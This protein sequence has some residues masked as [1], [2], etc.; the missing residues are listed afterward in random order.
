MLGEE[1][2][3]A[4]KKKEWLKKCGRKVNKNQHKLCL[5]SRNFIV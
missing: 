5:I 4:L 3:T 2:K 1:K